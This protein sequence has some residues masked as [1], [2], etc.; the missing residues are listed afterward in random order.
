MIIHK[1]NPY[2]T[3]KTYKFITLITPLDNE[4]SKY[5]INWCNNNAKNNPIIFI[6]HELDYNMYM[7]IYNTLSYIKI[8]INRNIQRKVHIR[9]VQTGFPHILK[10]K[11]ATNSCKNWVNVTQKF[12]IL[13]KNAHQRFC[14]DCQSNI[15]EQ[16]HHSDDLINMMDSLNMNNVDT[17]AM[18]IN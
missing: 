13:G 8:P 6:D 18:I 16:K 9:F 5:F 11:C 2:K 7:S 15:K 4:S 17:S 12:P 3:K 10:T 14:L 1:Y